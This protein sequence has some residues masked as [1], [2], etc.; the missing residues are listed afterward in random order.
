MDLK[1]VIIRILNSFE[2]DSGSP[3]TEYDTIYRYHDGTNDIRQVTLGR[4]WTE[5]G[6]SLWRVFESYKEKGG[7][8]ADKLLSYRSKSCKG[9]LPN[10]QEFLNLIKETAKSDSLFQGSEDQVFDE[11]Y[12]NPAYKYFSNNEFTQPLSLAVIVDSW[13]HSGGVLKFLVNKF[14]EKKPAFGGNEKKWIQS[15][16]EARLNW[17]SSA[18]ALLRNTVYRPKFFLNEIKKD[19]WSMTCPLIANDARI[20]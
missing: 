14:P 9:I 15:Y 4:G 1:E 18:S 6:G 19:N 3:E 16:L 2:N 20:C 13:L 11:V 10:D 17:L 7:T 8:N 12:W 5:C